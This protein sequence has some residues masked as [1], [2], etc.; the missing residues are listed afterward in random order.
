MPLLAKTH[1]NRPR[2]YTNYNTSRRLY[3]SF[4][5][6]IHVYIQHHS[7]SLHHRLS[8]VYK[9][10]RLCLVYRIISISTNYQSYS[11]AIQQIYA[12]RNK[13]TSFIVILHLR[14]NPLSHKQQQHSFNRLFFRTAWVSRY[15]K[16]KPFW[17]LLKQR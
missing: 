14:H 12:F 5:A 13:S 7:H 3:S 17:I 15:Q 2:L 11:S 4:D 9:I 10:S 1:I 8:T 16:D 6:R